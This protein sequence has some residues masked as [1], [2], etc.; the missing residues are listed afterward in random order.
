MN[1]VIIEIN[2][3]CCYSLS[4]RNR[5]TKSGIADDIM[6]NVNIFCSA[7]NS[8]TAYGICCLTAYCCKPKIIMINVITKRTQ[9]FFGIASGCIYTATQ[10]GI[11]IYFPTTRSEEHTSELQS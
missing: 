8:Y 1:Y 10:N 2:S 9:S 6:M 7:F 5:Q 3:L 4:Y 11:I